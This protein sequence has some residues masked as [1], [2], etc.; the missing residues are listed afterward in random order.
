MELN[1][2]IAFCILQGFDILESGH[3]APDLSVDPDG[4]TVGGHQVSFDIH[5]LPDFRLPVPQHFWQTG[6]GKD[7]SNG[8]A[9]KR[10]LV[11]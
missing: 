8:L 3:N 2:G 1:P 9:L 5:D 7:F 4:N 11:R 10:W 6:I